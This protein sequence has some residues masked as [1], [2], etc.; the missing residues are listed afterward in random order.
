MAYMN[1]E[2]TSSYGCPTVV[3]DE[4]NRVW[5]CLAP[6]NHAGECFLDQVS[7]PEYDPGDFGGNST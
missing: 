7:G 2:H 1:E 4:E 3:E 5:V 6:M